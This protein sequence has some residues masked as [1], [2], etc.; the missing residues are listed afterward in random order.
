M[1]EM[2]L[3]SA[4]KKLEDGIEE[5]ITYMDFPYQHWT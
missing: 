4:A 1:K 3:A 5:T 2:K